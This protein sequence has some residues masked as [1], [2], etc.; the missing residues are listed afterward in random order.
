MII[1]GE[2]YTRIVPGDYISY[3]QHPEANNNIAIACKTNYQIVNWVKRSVLGSDDLST[4]NEVLG[5][6]VHAAEVILLC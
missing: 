4:R 3:L 1:E 6:F 5:F 2:K